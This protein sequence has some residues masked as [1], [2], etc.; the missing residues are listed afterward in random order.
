M[1]LLLVLVLGLH[2]VDTHFGNV[3]VGDIL[4]LVV[5]ELFARHGIVLDGL[6]ALFGLKL[7]DMPGMWQVS[8]SK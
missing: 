7:I 8:F 1:H 6:L 5:I 3:N 2:V 4:D